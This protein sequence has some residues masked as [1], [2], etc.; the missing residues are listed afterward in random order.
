MLSKGRNTI[1]KITK[2][3][4]ND[5]EINYET[6]DYMIW[7]TK[8]NNQIT[9][10]RKDDSEVESWYDMWN[11]KNQLF[12]ED[13]NAI[14]IYPSRQNLIDGQ[15]QRH[16]FLLDY[17]GKIDFENAYKIVNGIINE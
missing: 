2:I 1:G 5:K 3:S 9:I 8:Q 7:V 17:N 15:N 4:S 13:T 6:E 16:L 12:G 11:I 10:A 14:E